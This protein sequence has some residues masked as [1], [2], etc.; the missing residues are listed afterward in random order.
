MDDERLEARLRLDP[1]G[2]RRHVVGQFRDR[3]ASA[4][5]APVRTAR[6]RVAR[7]PVGALLVAGIVIA[8]LVA[9]RPTGPGGQPTS[10][11]SPSPSLSLTSAALQAIVETWA[12]AN[13]TP[14]VTVA[15][16]GPT[17]EMWS[18]AVAPSGGAVP[19]VDARARIGET[20]RMFLISAVLALD[21]CGRLAPGAP[22]CPPRP[23]EGALS[24]DDHVS[25]WLPDWPTPDDT[26]VRSLLEG[27]S[28]LAPV[29]PTIADL[30]SRIALNPEADWS[31]ATL[32]ATAVQ[33]PRRFAPGA[34]SEPVDT[35]YMLLEDI[36]T[37]S[38]GRQAGLWIDET[39]ALH[40]G[41]NAT[42]I[43]EVAP[44]ALLAGQPHSGGPIADLDPLTLAI[45]GN[46]GGMASTSIDLARFAAAAWGSTIILDQRSVE[47]INDAAHG[48]RSPLGAR[49]SC[50]CR[51]DTRS[52]ISTTGHAVGWSTLAAY[53][54]ENRISLAAVLGTDVSDAALD[55]LW[56][57]IVDR[58]SGEAVPGS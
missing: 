42:F 30:R 12:R 24:I 44:G 32:L 35:E 23:S 29:G 41:L 56:M 9:V 39:T 49:G 6:P 52:I 40:L 48:H 28:G 3:L 26:T 34:R 4:A 15:V 27:S 11:P 45:I 50:P 18:A 7:Q 13:G 54:L 37:R 19:K 36:L 38:S 5:A 25:R 2:D 20:S 46:E 33:A 57:A 22:G 51:G 8:V 17:G 43:V 1:T 31:R 14:V 16:L 55:S 58:V 53:D 21:A 47:T 10:S